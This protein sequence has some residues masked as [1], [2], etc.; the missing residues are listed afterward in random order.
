[1]KFDSK[2]GIGE[3]TVTRQRIVEDK[4]Y[5]D[6]LVEIVG[7]YFDG[8]R[9]AS[10]VGRYSHGTTSTFTEDQLIGDPEFDQETGYPHD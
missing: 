4:I 1:M 7:I 9:R 8:D 2:F 5:E 6:H 10:Y 3:I